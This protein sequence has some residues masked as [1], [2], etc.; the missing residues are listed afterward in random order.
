MKKS[1]TLVLTLVIFYLAISLQNVQAWEFK[2]LPQNVWN[3]IQLCFMEYRNQILYRMKV[4]N[5]L[6]GFYK[7]LR[8]EY[9]DEAIRKYVIDP[10]L[11]NLF[12]FIQWDIP[13]E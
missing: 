9:Q 12:E 1:N 10:N 6:K 8:E 5:W 13:D 4:D 7:K 11:R 3:R 2:E